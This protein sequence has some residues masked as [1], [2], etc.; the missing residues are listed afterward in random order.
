MGD[1]IK[2]PLCN[3]R[4]PAD[5]ILKVLAR[6][7]SRPRRTKGTEAAR[8]RAR[9]VSTGEVVAARGVMSGNATS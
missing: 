7:A 6:K 2:C 5:R 4:V 1:K 9:K 8:E 3:S